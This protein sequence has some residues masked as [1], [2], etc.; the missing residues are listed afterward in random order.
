MNILNFSPQ[1][2]NER[3]RVNMYRVKDSQDKGLDKS[4]FK[5]QEPLTFALRKLLTWK[6]GGL[7][8]SLLVFSKYQTVL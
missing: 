2:E 3:I 6:N 7:D 8:K 4:P 5:G 1:S